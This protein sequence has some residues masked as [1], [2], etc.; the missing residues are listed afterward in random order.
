MK[1]EKHTKIADILK[2]KPEA[3]KIFE[4][5][6][7]GCTSCLGLQH[8]TLERGALMHGIDVDMLIEEINKLPNKTK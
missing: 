6:N 1:I 7:M 5:Y 3:V 2:E 8:E 4:K